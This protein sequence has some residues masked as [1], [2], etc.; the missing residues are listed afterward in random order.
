MATLTL[1][2]QSAPSAPSSGSAAIYFKTDGLLYWKDDAGTERQVAQT[3]GTIPFAAGT[4]SAPSIYLGGDTGTGLYRPSANVLAITNNGVESARYHAS[5]GISIGNIVDPGAGN[6]SVINSLT[7]GIDLRV[8]SAAPFI[9]FKDLT[10]ADTGFFVIADNSLF[11]V[12]QASDTGGNTGDLVT[13]ARATGHA[14]FTGGVSIGSAVDPGAGNLLLNSGAI[15]TGSTTALSLAT[16]GGTV[17]KFQ[18][19]T[20]TVNNFDFYGSATG[21]QLALD[22]V[23]SD[24]NIGLN[25]TLKGSGD[26]R[27]R[28]SGGAAEQVRINHT[29]SANRYITLTGSNGGNPTIGTSAGDLAISSS[30]VLSQTTL[31]KTSVSLTDGAAASVGTLTNAPT[32][33]NPTKWIP[34]DDNGTTRYIPSW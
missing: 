25:I 4:V 20:T 28:T 34:I 32:A 31:L 3:S 10:T 33:G 18:N 5:G 6:L 7:V 22:A 8:F 26:L 27:I 21:N 9:W 29:A 24:T 19:T 17:A 30:L 16:A 23:G 2:E 12:S 11:R 1:S 13:I 14:I 15:T